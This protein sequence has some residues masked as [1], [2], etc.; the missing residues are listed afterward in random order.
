MYLYI[1]MYISTPAP[2]SPIARAAPDI[3]RS[4]P[5]LRRFPRLRAVA[6]CEELSGPVPGSVSGDG[7]VV[8][9]GK[10]ENHRKTIGKP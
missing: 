7:T 4:C 1:C 8:T 9:V 10:W 2:P 5:A 3:F 6:Q